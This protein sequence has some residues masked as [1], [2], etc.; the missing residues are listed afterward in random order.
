MDLVLQD[1]VKAIAAAGRFPTSTPNQPWIHLV[2]GDA[3]KTN[4]AKGMMIERIEEV[5]PIFPP[6]MEAFL[7]KMEEVATLIQ[8]L[9]RDLFLCRCSTDPSMFRACLDLVDS[10]DPLISDE[11]ARIRNLR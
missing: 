4:I 9:D 11:I 7:P 3:H 5:A 10:R 2:I 8:E 1:V 6:S